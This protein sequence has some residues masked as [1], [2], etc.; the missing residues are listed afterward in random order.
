MFK[1]IR[2]LAII[3]AMIMSSLAFAEGLQVS[4]LSWMEGNWKGTTPAGTYE[5][6]FSSTTGGLIV[7]TAKMTDLHGALT[8]YEYDEIK[9]TENALQLTP[10]PFGMRGVS[11]K[12]AEYS[13]KRVVFENKQHDFPERITYSINDKGQFVSI[14]E[15]TQNG[16]PTRWEFVL[17]K[18]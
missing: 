15:G 11:F 2:R 9:V 7:G 5:N 3:S 6:S 13:D 12:V 10:M 8:F 14:V 1:V 18:N 17:N 4:D 16:K